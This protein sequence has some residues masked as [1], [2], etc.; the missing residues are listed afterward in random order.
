[1]IGRGLK[2]MFLQYEDISLRIVPTCA[3]TIQKFHLSQKKKKMQLVIHNLLKCD[4]NTCVL[5]TDGNK[6]VIITHIKK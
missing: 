2:F 4:V 6:K 3:A 1:M 5:F